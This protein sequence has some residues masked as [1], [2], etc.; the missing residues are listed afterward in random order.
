MA[1][2]A[3]SSVLYM[4]DG[5]DSETLANIARQN[6]LLPTES[7]GQTL[8]TP[9]ASTTSTAVDTRTGSIFDDRAVDNDD[10]QWLNE[11]N[12]K[13]NVPR[14][15]VWSSFSRLSEACCVIGQGTRRTSKRA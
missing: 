4:R 1:S 2:S 5:D 6:V 10:D 7:T 14:Y 15:A 12:Y 9:I 11:T 13:S 8:S 3:V